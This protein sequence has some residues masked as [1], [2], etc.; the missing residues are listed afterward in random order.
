MASAPSRVLPIATSSAASS[1][2]IDHPLAMSGGGGFFGFDAVLPERRGQQPQ[3][4][5]FGA[6]STSL[7]DEA[8]GA[9]ATEDIAVYTWRC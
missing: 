9:G 1:F 2:L 6:P 5:N 3:H 8:F 7:D 4:S